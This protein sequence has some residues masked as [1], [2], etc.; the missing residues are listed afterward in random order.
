MPLIGVAVGLY[1]SMASFNRQ[2]EARMAESPD[3]FVCG[4]SAIPFLFL[5]LI[6]GCL[7]GIVAGAAVAELV[8]WLVRR[9]GR[10]DVVKVGPPEVEDAGTSIF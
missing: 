8:T 10:C 4:D 9:K 7:G 3:G 2:I 5:G 6:G 1:L